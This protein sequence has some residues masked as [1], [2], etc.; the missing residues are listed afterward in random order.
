MSEAVPEYKEEHAGDGS[1][2]PPRGREGGGEVAVVLQESSVKRVAV[3][4]SQ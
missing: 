2:P 4:T 1:D 3:I